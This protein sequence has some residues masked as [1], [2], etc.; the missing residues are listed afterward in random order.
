MAN[1]VYVAVFWLLVICW[2]RALC[3]YGYD[4]DAVGWAVR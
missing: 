4:A 1:A 2:L 3:G